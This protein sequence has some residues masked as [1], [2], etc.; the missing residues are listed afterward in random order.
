MYSIRDLYHIIDKWYMAHLRKFRS[1]DVPNIRIQNCMLIWKVDFA[2]SET[3]QLSDFAANVLGDMFG[4][5]VSRYELL[6][7]ACT[8]FI[9]QESTY[10][11]A[12][13]LSC[14]PELGNFPA[15]AFSYP[16]ILESP[17]L[18]REK[19]KSTAA[20]ALLRPCK[21]S[22]RVVKRNSPGNIK[23]FSCPPQGSHFTVGTS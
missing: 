12:N 18:P 15:S 9:P 22:K 16:L 20:S 3:I 8:L 10:S 11:F 13:L 17:L 1:S 21:K 2:S 7:P 23:I 14:R 4:D 19:F 6:S 5:S